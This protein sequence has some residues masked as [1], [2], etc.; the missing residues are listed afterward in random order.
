MVNFIE[1]IQSKSFDN[2]IVYNRVGFYCI[3][4]TFSR[5][6]TKF[7]YEFFNGGTEPRRSMGG[8]KFGNILPIKISKCQTGKEYV[9]YQKLSKSSDFYY[10]EPGLY[11]PITDIVEAM[12]TPIQEKHNNSKNCIT[13]KVSRVTQKIEIYLSNEGSDLAF[14]STDLGHVLGS[15]IGNEFGL[16]LRGK[17]TNQNLLTTLSAYTLS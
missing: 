5:R 14:F 2:R 3:Y 15:N 7:F 10:L 8:C 6:N 17:G 9:F 11:P 4:T 16:M 13:N 12:N 1:K